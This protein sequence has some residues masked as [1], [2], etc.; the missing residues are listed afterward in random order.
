VRNLSVKL[1]R[2]YACYTN[3]TLYGVIYSLRYYPRFSVTAV[4]LGTYYPQIRRSTYNYI[5]LVIYGLQ[6]TFVF[7][8]GF[9]LNMIR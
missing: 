3:I 1:Y 8:V 4:G 5:L 6:L 7:T 9:S 2:I